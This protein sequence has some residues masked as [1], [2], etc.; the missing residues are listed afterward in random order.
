MCG[1]IEYILQLF[2]NTCAHECVSAVVLSLFLVLCI[3]FLV[4][5]VSHVS[6]DKQNDSELE[7]AMRTELRKSNLGAIN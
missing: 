6:I 3:F 7:I 2:L 4:A 5:N 1:G